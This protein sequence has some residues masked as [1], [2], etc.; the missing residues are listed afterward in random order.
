MSYSEK[1]TDLLKKISV[2]ITLIKTDRQ[3]AQW[4]FQRVSGA[5]LFFLI[6]FHSH[7]IMPG[8]FSG[9]NW[10]YTDYIFALS[11]PINKIITILFFRLH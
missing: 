6:I 5:V 8:F 11:T 10:S 3:A 7:F 4:L 1:P 9:G 2:V